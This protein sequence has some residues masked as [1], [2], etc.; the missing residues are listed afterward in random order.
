MKSKPATESTLLSAIFFVG[1][2]IFSWS[3]TPLFAQPLVADDT[4]TLLLKFDEAFTPAFGAPPVFSTGLTFQEGLHGQAAYFGEGSILEFA[5]Q[6]G[7]PTAAG[8]I[9]F[10]VKPEWSSSGTVD[11]DF[12]WWGDFP[13]SFYLRHYGGWLLATFN[14]GTFQN[15][16]V[17]AGHND[18]F[19][20]TGWNHVA[21]CWSSDFVR[22]FLNGKKLREE[23]PAF[24]FVSPQNGSLRIGGSLSAGPLDAAVDE[25]RVSDRAR[26]ENE[27]FHS[28]SAGLASRVEGL[29]IELPTHNFHPEWHLMPRVSAQIGSQS[30]SIPPSAVSWSSSAAAVAE[31][32][33]DGRIHAK[34]AGSAK[35][36]ASLGEQVTSV[37]MNVTPP[38]LPPVFE[39][40]DPLLAEPVADAQVIMPV[41]ILRFLPTQDGVMLDDRSA[42]DFWSLN[43][44]GLDYMRNRILE[45]DRRIKFAVE[46]ATRFRGYKRPHAKPYLGYKVVAYI[47]VYEVTPP[48]FSDRKTNGF[49]RFSNVLI[50]QSISMNQGF[51]RCGF[52]SAPSIRSIQALTR[53]TTLPSTRAST[54][55]LICPVR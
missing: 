54:G 9:E 25:F 55:N 32:R 20:P 28:Y 6:P 17:W 31:V 8:T 39:T 38:K 40:I 29:V 13:G 49:I 41:V 53:I 19:D 7:L 12:I 48:R 30:L 23:V 34:S 33:A 42:P 52:G 47:T 44:V 46:E 3:P 51:V 36:Y 37:T 43:P 14:A 4:T 24:P 2:S 35:L 45:F 1:W 27:I 21:I 16:T 10:W 18:T 11:R 26:T 22:I 5:N 15:Y 50:W